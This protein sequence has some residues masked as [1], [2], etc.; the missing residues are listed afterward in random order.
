MF[1]D[2]KQSD[3]RAVGQSSGRMVGRSD[4]RA[5]GDGIGGTKAPEGKNVIA[6]KMSTAIY[7]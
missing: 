3:G 7:V 4:G 5:G 6:N 2:T 1:E